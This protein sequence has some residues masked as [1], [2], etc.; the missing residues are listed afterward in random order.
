M[1]CEKCQIEFEFKNS[2]YCSRSCANSRNHTI[3]T[4]TKISTSLKNRI[5][6][7]KICPF[8]KKEFNYKV[9][10]Q[11][12]CSRSCVTKNSNKNGLA[13]KVGLAS[14]KSQNKRSKNEIYFSELCKKEFNILTNENIFNGWDADIILPELK[15][16]VLWNGNWHYKQISKNQSLLQVQNRDKIKLKEI[17]NCGFIPYIIKDEGKHNIQ[18]VDE[19]FLEFKQYLKNLTV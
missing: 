16:A 13:N 12:F 15:I 7:R 9:K 2:I 17:I 3:E 14:A 19:K 4:R 1:K 10:K 5:D 11:K 18:F 6:K 8:C